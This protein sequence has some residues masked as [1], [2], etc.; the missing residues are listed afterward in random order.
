MVLVCVSYRVCVRAVN[1]ILDCC[2]LVGD[3]SHY[4]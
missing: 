2:V 3:M 1:E 4:V